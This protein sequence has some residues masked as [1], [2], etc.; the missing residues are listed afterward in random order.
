MATANRHLLSDDNGGGGDGGGGGGGDDAA[1]LGSGTQIARTSQGCYVHRGDGK[2]AG[3]KRCTSFQLGGTT[4]QLAYSIISAGSRGT[5]LN[6]ALLVPNAPANQWYALGLPTGGR[7]RM[8]GTNAVVVQGFGAGAVAADFYLGGY[9]FTSFKATS[10]FLHNKA[11]TLTAGITR[12]NTL[13][14]SFSIILSG[15]SST[16]NALLA[17]GPITTGVM[18]RHRSVGVASLAG[19]ITPGRA[20]G[21]YLNKKAILP[22]KPSPQ[23][24]KP[25]PQ[26]LSPGSSSPSPTPSNKCSLTVGGVTTSYTA[27]YPMQ[28][29]TG[30]ATGT[31]YYSLSPDGSTLSVGFAAAPTGLGYAAWGYLPN[32]GMMGGQAVFAQDCGSG[33]AQPYTATLGGYAAS[34]FTSATVSFASVTTGVTPS[35]QLAATFKMPWPAGQSSITVAMANGASSGGTMSVHPGVPVKYS[36]SKTLSQA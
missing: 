23:P 21:P 22:V 24:V 18:Q 12:G 2:V 14:G 20:K 3:Y 29:F 28:D 35:G 6:G 34:M 1:N 16:L 32:G 36:L 4:V 27:C 11:A 30:T 17:T 31:A 25:S 9:S 7:T 8:V 10:G 26:P 13:V 33:C 15:P 19:S 5:L